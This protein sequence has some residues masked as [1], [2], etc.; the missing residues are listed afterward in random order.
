MSPTGTPRQVPVEGSHS[1][2]L[3]AD[4]TRHARPKLEQQQQQLFLVL[5]DSLASPVLAARYYMQNVLHALLHQPDIVM[6]ACRHVCAVMVA[7]LSHK[8]TGSSSWLS[9]EEEPRRL[10]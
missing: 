9:P 7:G 4:N 1:W 2:L 5:S 10:Q 8:L 6:V 3:Y